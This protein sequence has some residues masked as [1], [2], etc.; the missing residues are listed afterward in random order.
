[1][2]AVSEFCTLAAGAARL[3]LRVEVKERV[4]APQQLR[5]N[6]FATP[7]QHMHRHMSLVAVLQRDRRL[8]HRRYLVR[9]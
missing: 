2:R 6:L 1:M 3:N 5:L 4:E 7:F 8:A 9:G